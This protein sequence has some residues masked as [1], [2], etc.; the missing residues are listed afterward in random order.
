MW[1][2]VH[3]IGV[4]EIDKAVDINNYRSQINLYQGKQQMKNKTGD[5]FSEENEY[6]G[7]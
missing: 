6:I 3:A 1:F 7:E 4:K 5:T 2:D